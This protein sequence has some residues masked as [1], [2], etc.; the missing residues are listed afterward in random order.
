MGSTKIF[1]VNSSP[2]EEN[3]TTAKLLQAFLKGAKEAGAKTHIEYIFNQDI[4][5]CKGCV[6]CWLNTPG[7]CVQ[8]DDMKKLLD[9]IKESDVVVYAT[10]LYIHNVNGPMKNF[11]D[12]RLPLINPYVEMRNGF[13][14]HLHSEYVKYS[15]VVLVS[16]CGFPGLHNFDPIVSLF[17]TMCRFRDQEFVGAILRPNSGGLD[18]SDRAKIVF[19]AASEAGAQLVKDG[20]FSSETLDRISKQY[21]SDEHFIESLNEVFKEIR[22]KNKVE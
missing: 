18:H 1:A 13:A 6:S 12:R 17:E 5:P 11:L 10:P 20:F 7:E 8:K 9:K 19:T 21:A 14:R 3:G 15:K 4:K 22:I 16:T 2:S